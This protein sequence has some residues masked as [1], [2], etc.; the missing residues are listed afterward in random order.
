M[1]G[2]LKHLKDKLLSKDITQMFFEI[3]NLCMNID[4][5]SLLKI[6]FDVRIRSTLIEKLKIEFLKKIKK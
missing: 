6:V 5:D 1:K 2:I 3:N 4:E